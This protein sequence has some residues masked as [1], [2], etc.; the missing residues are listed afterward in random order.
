MTLTVRQFTESLEAGRPPADLEAALVGLWWDAKG[1]WDQAHKA[2][3][4][5][6][7][8]RGMQVDAYLHRKEGDLGNAA[9]WYRPAGRTLPDLSLEAEHDLLMTELLAD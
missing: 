9:Y 1:D 5:L 2:V 6:E 7:D 4:H 8:Q 3:D